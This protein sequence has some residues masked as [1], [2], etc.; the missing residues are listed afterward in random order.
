MNGKLPAFAHHVLFW[1]N[2]PNNKAITSEFEKE[3]QKLSAIPQIKAFHVGTPADV[4][5]RP[6][7]DKSYTFSLLVFFDSSADHDEYQQHSLHQ[8]FL[9]KNKHLFSSIK[10]YDADF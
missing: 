3:L 7:L 4:P 6:V 9:K 8:D 10:V 1:L 5:D 2:E